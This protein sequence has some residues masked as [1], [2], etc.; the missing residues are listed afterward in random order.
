MIH[1]LGDKNTCHTIVHDIIILDQNN[2]KRNEGMTAT[3]L[4]TLSIGIHKSRTADFLHR[5]SCI[6]GHS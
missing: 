4:L 6:D 3:T 5:D 1:T 2:L